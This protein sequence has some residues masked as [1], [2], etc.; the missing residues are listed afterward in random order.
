MER[1][2][3]RKLLLSVFGASLLSGCGTYVP[4]VLEFW[5]GENDLGFKVNAVTSQVQCELAQAVRSLIADDKRISKQFNIP[6]RAQWL[7][8]WGA[9]VTLTFVIDEKTLF[10]PGVT[11][12]R[13][14][15]NVITAF[16]TGGNVTSAQNFSLGLGGTFSA[17]ANRTS[18]VS[19]FFVF[20]NFIDPKL[21]NGG[22]INRT[23]LPNRVNGDI[24]VQSD[25][26][27]KEWL[28]ASALPG[29]TGI[30]AFPDKPPPTPAK[31]VISHQ[32]KYQVV[33]NGGITPT[34]TLVRVTAGSS[35]GSLPLFGANRDRT[36]DLLITMGPT[37][38]DAGVP[39]LAPVA[40]NS[41]LAS[42]I[43][44]SVASNIKSV[45]P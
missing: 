16:P 26:K 11:L 1:A 4:D 40:V 22:P 27:L 35:S 34:W 10:N 25:L 28:Y 15:E 3:Q 9:Q 2:F 12:K 29:F 44:A 39:I 24:F 30:V 38:I 6:R 42:E 43:G 21:P 45:Q 32:I 17:G 14:L 18:K 5:A 7:E 36:Q 20:K 31:D 8:N 13:P 23:C 33:S 37:F 41:H 19:S